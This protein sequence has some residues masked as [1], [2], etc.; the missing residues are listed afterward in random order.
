MVC[1]CYILCMLQ[2]EAD[3]ARYIEKSEFMMGALRAAQSC[4]LPDWFIGAGFVRDTV[5]N[6]QS[7]LPVDYQFKDLDLGYFDGVSQSEQA[8]EELSQRLSERFDVNWEIVN[9]AYAHTYNEGVAPYTSAVDG[10]SHWV[11][12]ATCV[13]A[14]LDQDGK[15]LILA[16]WGLD[17]LF[18]MKLRISPC[19]AGN[20]YYEKLFRERVAAK[21]WLERWPLLKF[22]E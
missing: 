9:Q 5:W 11:E 16:P 8:D 18:S 10:L 21:K 15:V 17:D 13:A 19:H 3:L 12:T 2:T 4:Q 7:G 20:A 22:V 14:T 6:I 1:L